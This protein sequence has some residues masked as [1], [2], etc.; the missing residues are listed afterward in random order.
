MDHMLNAITPGPE[1][2]TKKGIESVRQRITLLK[3]HTALSLEELKALII[4]T[5]CHDSLMLTP[6]DVAA[7]EAIEK[8]YLKEEFVKI[9]Q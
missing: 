8:T 7:I 1:K 9:L 2:L 4:N 6:E 5:L 3:D